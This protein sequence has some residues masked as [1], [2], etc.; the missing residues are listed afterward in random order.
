ME[1]Q[2]RILQLDNFCSHWSIKLPMKFF[3]PIM[4][5]I[6]AKIGGRYIHGRYNVVREVR[7][8]GRG[9]YIQIGR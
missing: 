9:R 2:E 3:A 6:S 1:S 4:R 5:Y 7:Q 8:R